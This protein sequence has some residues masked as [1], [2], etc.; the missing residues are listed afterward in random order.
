MRNLKSSLRPVGPHVIGY[1][2]G[3]VTH[4]IFSVGDSGLYYA[5]SEPRNDVPIRKHWNSFGIFRQASS[6]QTITVEI[7]I[8]TDGNKPMVAGF[9]AADARTGRIY[10]MHN[11]AIGGGRK[12]VG[13]EAFLA[14][15]GMDQVS[16]STSKATRNGLVIGWVDDPNLAAL[17]W[18][19]VRLVQA[20][21]MS[22]V[23]GMLPSVDNDRTSPQETS[24]APEFWGAK[25]GE[26][27][28]FDYMAYHGLV[29]HELRRE[30]EAAKKN[31]ERIG[32]SRLIDLYVSNCNG[33]VAVYEVKTSVDRQSLYTAIGQLLV[34]SRGTAAKRFLIIPAEGSVPRDIAEAIVQFDISPRRFE[35]AGKGVGAHVKF[36]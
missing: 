17:I 32:N 34:H 14:F 27:I 23:S 3:N 36:L 20:F 26:R 9:F 5:Y 2:G 1:Q 6:A 13:Q 10:L 12:G 21:K 33:R 28:S 15:A 8:P 31:G 4:P 11:G 35:I 18:G 22:A 19:Y 7:N 25:S 29:V 16:A 30:L 24:Y